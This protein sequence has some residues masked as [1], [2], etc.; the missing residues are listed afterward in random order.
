[1]ANEHR[2]ESLLH[3]LKAIGEFVLLVCGIIGIA[4]DRVGYLRP[5]AAGAPCLKCHGPADG[6]S[7]G[8]RAALQG[9]YPSDQA[10]GFEAGEFRGFFWAEVSK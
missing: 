6:L 3:L 1:M 5:I 8:V 10:T 7:P 2:P 9:S 4:G